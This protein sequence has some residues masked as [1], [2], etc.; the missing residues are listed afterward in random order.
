MTGTADGAARGRGR[1]VCAPHAR[2]GA[3]VP[4]PS[5]I[6]TRLMRVADQ[7]D[8]DD[9]LMGPPFAG[10]AGARLTKVPAPWTLPATRATSRPG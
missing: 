3:A 7:P 4:G 5:P 9:D 2:R 10:A 6:P 8:G 1:T